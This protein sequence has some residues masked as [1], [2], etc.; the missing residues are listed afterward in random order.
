MI[1]FCWRR[2]R[3]GVPVRLGERPTNIESYSQYALLNE[4]T[5]FLYVHPA[6]LA[7]AME[8]HPASFQAGHA[9]ITDI[10]CPRGRII[11]SS[12][13]IHSKP[14]DPPHVQSEVA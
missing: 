7:T 8:K 4:P 3:A 5:G 2:W 12:T 9:V 10:E 6:D 1:R 13:P 14:I 11:I